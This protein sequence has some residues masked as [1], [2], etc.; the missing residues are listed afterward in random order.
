MVFLQ[1]D[2][3]DDRINMLIRGQSLLAVKEQAISSC[4]EA[5]I[6][7][8]L[9]PVI[10]PGMNEGEIGRLIRY[11][12]DRCDIV[13]G[14]HFQPAAYMGRYPEH[15]GERCTMFDIM[16]EIERQTEAQSAGRICTPCPQDTAC[17][18]FIPHSWSMGTIRSHALPGQAKGTAVGK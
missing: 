6:P 15:G 18:V 4:R 14:I 11:A 10:F 9:V 5:G 17:A 3:T 13:K 8:A 2:S 16:E 1:F 12:A 7:V